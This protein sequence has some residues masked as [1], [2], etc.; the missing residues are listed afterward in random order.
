[1]N[2]SNISNLIFVL[3]SIRHFLFTHS[4]SLKFELK[5]QTDLARGGW[6][7]HF[8]APAAHIYGASNAT[9]GEFKNPPIARDPSRPQMQQH[10]SGGPDVS[11]VH[12]TGRSW[13]AVTAQPAVNGLSIIPQWVPYFLPACSNTARMSLRERARAWVC[14]CISCCII[15][16]CMCL[17]PH[18][19]CNV[20]CFQRREHKR[21]HWNARILYV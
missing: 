4:R 13:L 15:D 6:Q 16:G 18:R 3:E 5:R 8:L 2:K 19:G 20:P 12:Q 10:A 7:G 1:M 9:W 14:T 11:S 21:N 17:C